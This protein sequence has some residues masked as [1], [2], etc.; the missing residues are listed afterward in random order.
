MKI[1]KIFAREILDSRGTPTI[2]CSLVLDNGIVAHSA[3]PSGASVGEHE[4]VELR[5]NDPKRYG[6]RGVLKAI[7]NIEE[8]IAP[9]LIGKVADVTECDKI[10][11]SLD[12]SENKSELGANAMLAVSM[13]V[14]RAQALA[15][16]RFL[17]QTI[18]RL[19]ITKSSLPGAM[20]NVLNG[21]VHANNGICFQEFMIMPKREENFSEVL[22]MAVDVYKS[23][24]TLLAKKGYSTGVGDE[25]GFAPRFKDKGSV[26]FV[27]LDFLLQAVEHAGYRPYE[28]IVFC[29]DVAAT[30]FFSKKENIYDMYGEKFDAKSMIDFYKNL[31]TKYPI[32]SIE[33]GL[34]ENDWSGFAL[35]TEELGEKTMLVGDDIFVS[36]SVCIERGIAEKVANAVLIKPNQVGTI[37]E[38]LAS[39]A[40]AQK[41]NYDVVVS[42]R[43]GETNDAFISDL[44]VGVGANF[45]KAGAPARGERVAKYN[46]LLA[47]AESF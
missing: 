18:S 15:H 16:D 38:T 21:G 11:L 43:S 12:K 14:I 35:M 28:D 32:V 47:L 5:D 44:A 23:L 19:A 31:I 46:R 9:A 1:S 40:L 3:V 37:T 41:N 27:A 26:E 6:G 42:H 29:L 10:M 36:N 24:Q 34:E 8:K 2:A 20:F 17:Y 22:R 45:F 4:A 7:K 25:G 30:Q 33:D 39:I 13:A